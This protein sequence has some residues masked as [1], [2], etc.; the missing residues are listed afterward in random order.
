MHRP[1]PVYPEKQT[2]SES[3]GMSQRC[4]IRKSHRSAAVCDRSKSYE[5]KQE[6]FT[7]HVGPLKGNVPHRDAYFAQA[8][9]GIE[10]QVHDPMFVSKDVGRRRLTIDKVCSGP[11]AV[12]HVR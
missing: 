12:R 3:F 5:A 10:F 11:T 9:I 1:L 8:P 6:P 2:F 7:A 4:Q